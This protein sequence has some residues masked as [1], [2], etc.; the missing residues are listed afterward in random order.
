MNLGNIFGLAMFFSFQLALKTKKVI[1]R[2]GH[3]FFNMTRD[4]KCRIEIE[5][6]FS[7]ARY[8]D[9]KGLPLRS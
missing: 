7:L 5:R 2:A 4:F 3:Y 9:E 6:N 8:D 1:I